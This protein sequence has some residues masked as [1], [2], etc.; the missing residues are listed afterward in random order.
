MAAFRSN[1]SAFLRDSDNAEQAGLKA[2][3][4][5]LSNAVKRNLKGGYTTGDFVTGASVN[6][7]T[8]GQVFYEGR[9][10]AIKV[11]TDLLYN[12]YWEVGFTPARGVYSP[13]IGR[14][15]QGPI[16]FQ[17]VEKWRPALVDNREEIRAAYTRVYEARMSRWRTN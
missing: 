17:R 8:I 5:V 13:G 12:L 4:Y 10:W 7:V 11:G 1:L 3:A 14:N 9:G 2:G 16:M 15:T 6:H